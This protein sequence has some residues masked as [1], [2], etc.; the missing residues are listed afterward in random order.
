MTLTTRRIEHKLAVIFVVSQ[1]TFVELHRSLGVFAVHLLRNRQR[2]QVHDLA[3]HQAPYHAGNNA[4]WNLTDKATQ[5]RGP[6]CPRPHLCQPVRTRVGLDCLRQEDATKS[7]PKPILELH[8]SPE[9]HQS[10]IPAEK[11]TLVDHRVLPDL[12]LD[13]KQIQDER[14]NDSKNPDWRLR[15]TGLCSIAIQLTKIAKATSMAFLAQGI[16]GPMLAK[17]VQGFLVVF[18]RRDESGDLDLL[19]ATA[20][21]P[22][23]WLQSLPV[24]DRSHACVSNKWILCLHKEGQREI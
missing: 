16:A 10:L 21:L 6:H 15:K 8:R 11:H 1:Q 18:V 4:K 17:V 13:P 22:E 14:G 5:S 2:H 12:V 20:C 24:C 7:S 3:Q 9:Q 19:L 23:K